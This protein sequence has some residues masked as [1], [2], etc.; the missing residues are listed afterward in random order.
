[1]SVWY[2]LIQEYPTMPNR[3]GRFP[4][5]KAP[6]YSA[7]ARGGLHRVCV[8]ASATAPAATQTTR[9]VRVYG[10]TVHVQYT[11]PV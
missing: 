10:C 9:C 8:R 2:I 5:E 6:P 7:F 3:T 11:N 1:M 4:R